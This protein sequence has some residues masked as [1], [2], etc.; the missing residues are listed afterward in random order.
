M[1]PLDPSGEGTGEGRVGE[2]CWWPGVS[3]A[4]AEQGPAAAGLENRVPRTVTSTV[5]EMRSLSCPVK[6]QA[7]THWHLLVKVREEVDPE[8]VLLVQLVA[9]SILHSIQGM[10]RRRIFQ[11]G[12]PESRQSSSANCKT[13]QAVLNTTKPCV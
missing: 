3:G 6:A 13:R 11:E 8:R 1:L 12:V 9:I 5:P 4:G 7:L 2:G 10:G